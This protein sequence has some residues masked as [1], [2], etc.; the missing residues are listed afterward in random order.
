MELFMVIIVALGIMALL[1]FGGKFYEEYQKNQVRRFN[2]TFEGIVNGAAIKHG[3]KH[4]GHLDSY[5]PSDAKEA[6]KYV[7]TLEAVVGELEAAMAC[8]GKTS[9]MYKRLSSEKFA[10]QRHIRLIE[11]VKMHPDLSELGAK[12]VVNTPP[13]DV[14]IP[15]N[16]QPHRHVGNSTRVN[17]DRRRDDEDF[18]VGFAAHAGYQPVVMDTPSSSR[19]SDDSSSRCVDGT[20]SRSYDYD[21][22]SP[23]SS[24]SDSCGGG[25]GD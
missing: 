11:V 18:A 22:G 19:S 24:G 16:S 6:M 1:V 9:K 17:H 4:V 10:L 3:W 23:S 2:D 14:Q 13:K 5:W 12:R 25:G 20:P 7:D 21:S 8:F 15:R